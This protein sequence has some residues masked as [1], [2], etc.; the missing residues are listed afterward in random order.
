[1]LPAMSVLIMVKRLRRRRQYG[2]RIERIGAAM[3]TGEADRAKVVL[4]IDLQSLTLPALE[5]ALALG[6]GLRRELRVLLVEREPLVAEA[7]HLRRIVERMARRFRLQWT[8]DHAVGD[9]IAFA[10]ERMRQ[11]DALVMHKGPPAAFAIGARAAFSALGGRPVLALAGD[12]DTASTVLEAGWAMA[13]VIGTELRVLIAADAAAAAAKERVQRWAAKRRTDA[14]LLPIAS[15]N[16]AV[17][18]RAAR[19]NEAGA[20]LWPRPAAA[21]APLAFAELLGRLPCPLVAL[22]P[23]STVH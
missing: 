3:G 17:L 1:M 6:V 9:C 23:V 7:A 2:G 19:A 14:R 21:V 10:F 18:A 13:G 11:E 8:L 22:P 4:A 15:S 20:L 12:A 5:A 16:A